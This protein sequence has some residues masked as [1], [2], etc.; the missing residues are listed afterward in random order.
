MVRFITHKE[1]F[2]HV[3]ENWKS[4]N[5]ILEKNEKLDLIINECEVIMC[6]GATFVFK[7][8]KDSM[9]SLQNSMICKYLPIMYGCYQNL[10]GLKD[11]HQNL[12]IERS[13]QE[14]LRIGVM[15]SINN[16]VSTAKQL[17]DRTREFLVRAM[18][19]EPYW[20]G[21][22]DEKRSDQSQRFFPIGSQ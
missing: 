4:C 6:K 17:T 15:E 13:T 10:S 16:R 2:D 5:E 18:L 12:F 8:V 22:I 21:F 9:M 14:Y 11:L 3:R 19:M 1:S 20:K 7:I